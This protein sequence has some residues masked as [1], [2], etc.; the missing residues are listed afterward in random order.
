MFRF[1]LLLFSRCL[2]VVAVFDGFDV[3][4]EVVLWYLVLVSFDVGVAVIQGFSFGFR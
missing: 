1:G 3:W 2:G 4:V